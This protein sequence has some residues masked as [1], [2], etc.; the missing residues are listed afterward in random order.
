MLC[1]KIGKWKWETKLWEES[2]RRSQKNAE[3]AQNM[4]LFV[5]VIVVVMYY[6]SM[7]LGSFHCRS[8]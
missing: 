1:N 8:P 2:N 5:L 6:Q 7:W 4:Y 3:S